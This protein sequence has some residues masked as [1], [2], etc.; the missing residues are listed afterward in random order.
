MLQRLN[1]LKEITKKVRSSVPKLKKIEL[2]PEQTAALKK[3]GLGIG[4][5][6]QL[7]KMSAKK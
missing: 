4:D 1:D 7:R 6:N 5:L 3:L 2:N